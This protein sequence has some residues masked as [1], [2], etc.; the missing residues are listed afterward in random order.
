MIRGI[1]FQRTKEN[2]A[3]CH[4]HTTSFSAPLVPPRNSRF[5]IQIGEIC[6]F[7][8]AVLSEKSVEIMK[9]FSEHLS[10]DDLYRSLPE[11]YS[12]ILEAV[13]HVEDEPVIG[14]FHQDP[15]SDSSGDDDSETDYH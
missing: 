10:E 14:E 8:A 11:S 6:G 5:V 4:L 9:K 3:I 15:D 7:D 2:F 1:L 13:V 12:E